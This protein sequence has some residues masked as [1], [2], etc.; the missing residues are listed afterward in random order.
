M[1][2]LSALNFH[3]F[4]CRHFASINKTVLCIRWYH[5]K[6]PKLFLSWRSSW[7]RVVK[8]PFVPVEIL[9]HLFNS[10]LPSPLNFICRNLCRPSR[11]KNTEPAL[12]YICPVTLNVGM[13]WAAT[14][15][16]KLALLFLFLPT[17]S[18]RTNFNCFDDSYHHIFMLFQAFPVHRDWSRLEHSHPE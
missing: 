12:W 18:W 3:T 15:L 10:L 9:Q 6:L 14:T 8:H 13:N 1:S 4:S 5:I 2:I 16:Y 7:N 11:N 17:V